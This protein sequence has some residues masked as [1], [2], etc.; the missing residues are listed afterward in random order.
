MAGIV[1]VGAVLKFM[2]KIADHKD[3]VKDCIKLALFCKFS[4]IFIELAA[5]IS[6][7]VWTGLEITYLFF[8]CW[9]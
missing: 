2:P 9:A 3:L 5:V 8:H 1:C 6:A 7:D 4:H